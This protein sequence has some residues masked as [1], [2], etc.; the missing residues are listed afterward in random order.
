MTEGS[1]DPLYTLLERISFLL[2]EELRTFATSEGLKLAQL[3]ALIFLARANRYSDTTSAVVDYLGAT[4]GSVSQTLSAL[5][6]KGLV[7]RSPDPKDGRVN[8]CHVTQAGGRVVRRAI[9]ARALPERDHSGL[10]ASLRQL[11]REMQRQRGG[12][13]FGVCG[14]CRH[15]QRHDR[16]RRCGLTGEALTESESR[17]LCREHEPSGAPNPSVPP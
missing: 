7:E 10:A 8:H 14:T 3:E 9:V 11:L 5:E 17:L 13:S 6:R 15:F 12:R 2:R 4:K 1:D 16:G